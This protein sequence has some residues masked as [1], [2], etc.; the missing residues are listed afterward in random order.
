MS[1]QKEDDTKGRGLGEEK[2]E[3][4]EA[5]K[6]ATN[7]VESRFLWLLKK[8]LSYGFCFKLLLQFLPQ[9]LSLIDLTY[10]LN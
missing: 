4:E 5:R 10:L 2:G 8:A 7:D 9:F 6:L 1:E 3:E